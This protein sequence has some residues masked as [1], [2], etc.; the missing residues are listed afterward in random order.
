[1]ERMEFMK[2]RTRS[3][4]PA[5]RLWLL[6]GLL[7]LG[8]ISASALAQSVE[9]E[10]R[11]DS[12]KVDGVLYR[13]D[14]RTGLLEKLAKTPTGG[15]NWI[16]QEVP[17]GKPE[18]Q[19]APKE[20][21]REVTTHKDAPSATTPVRA[22]AITL[23][24]LDGNAIPEA[25]TDANR[26]AASGTIASYEGKLGIIQTLH[27]TDRITGILMLKN[28]GDK[29]LK[30]VELSVIVPVAGS[31]QSEIHRFLLQEK[32][33]AGCAAAPQPAQNGKEAQSILQKVDVPAPAGGVKGSP[34]IKITYL[35]F[36]E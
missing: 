7:T 10:N 12:V 35:K 36:A 16:A 11:Y 26:Q 14:K 28:L 31:E 32:P 20:P 34:E 6:A 13:L 29:H 3:G 33:A 21:A 17:T 30:T 25:I 8:G 19:D 15:L 9:E 5:I 1:M 27:I 24:D 18:A 22:T 4:R 2:M 23:V